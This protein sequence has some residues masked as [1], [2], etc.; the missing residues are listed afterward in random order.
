MRL[1]KF[2][3]ELIIVDQLGKVMVY[4][5]NGGEDYLFIEAVGNLAARFE[6]QSLGI[7][8][9]GMQKLLDKIERW[10]LYGQEEVLDLVAMAN[11][12][13]AEMA[14]DGDD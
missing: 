8:D 11:A 9:G 10:L 5:A 7:V 1:I 3:G 13:E 4:T 14:E 6:H 12:V 2:P